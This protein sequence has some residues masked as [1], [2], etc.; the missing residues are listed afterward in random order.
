MHLA[1]HQWGSVRHLQKIIHKVSRA[2]NKQC[3]V[4]EAAIFF[5][6]SVDSPLRGWEGGKALSTMEFFFYFFLFFFIY[7]F[8][9]ILFFAASL[10]LDFGYFNLLILIF[11]IFLSFCRRYPIDKVY[12]IINKYTPSISLIIKIR[13][14]LKMNHTDSPKFGHPTLTSNIHVLKSSLHRKNIFCNNYEWTVSIENVSGL[15]WRF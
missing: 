8:V 15:E 1:I 3:V 11:I 10:T 14:Q 9:A 6:F 2:K 7:L 4:R 5:F 13:L 12:F